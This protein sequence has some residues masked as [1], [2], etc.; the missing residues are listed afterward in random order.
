MKVEIDDHPDEKEIEELLSKLIQYN[1]KHL[2][3]K[4]R[5]PLAVWYKNNKDQV[6]AGITGNTFGNWLEI[7]Y[8]YVNED[9]RGTGV[10]KKLLRQMEQA[11]K[12]RGCRF[13]FLDTFSFQAKPFYE[14]NGYKELFVLHNY[15]LSS[16]K[17]YLIKEL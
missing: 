13:S 10:G 11:A 5:S 15:P 8:F 3:I 14:K 1:L 17:H 12:S 16:R 2:E 6:L 7:K 4:K 9:L